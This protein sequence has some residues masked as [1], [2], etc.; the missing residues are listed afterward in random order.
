MNLDPRAK[1]I[2]PVGLSGG[3]FSVLNGERGYMAKEAYQDPAATT[4]L[5]AARVHGV[6][7]KE[8]ARRSG[9]HRVHI[10]RIFRGK[11]RLTNDAKERLAEA[12]RQAIV[13]E[14]ATQAA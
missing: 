7:Q 5:V 13:E 9:L 4:I 3:A 14:P 1:I 2:R 6:D 12:L 8:L 10:S 11:S